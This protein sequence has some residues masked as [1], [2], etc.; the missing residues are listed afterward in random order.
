MM[1]FKVT[2]WLGGRMES[3][4]F[5]RVLKGVGKGKGIII[6]YNRD[7]THSLKWSARL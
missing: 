1:V 5:V 7:H 3:V 4:L 6:V 2:G